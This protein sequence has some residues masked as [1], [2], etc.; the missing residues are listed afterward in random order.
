MP[1]LERKI[2]I[3]SSPD[4]IYKIV[5]DGIN[6]PKWNPS[7][8]AVIEKEDK[9]IQLETNIGGITI[10]DTKNEENKSTT[11][12]MESSD[13]NSIGYILNPKKTD[14]TEVTMWTEFDNKKQLK[15][16]KKTADRVLEGLK[17]YAEYIEGGGDPD[18]YKKWEYL[19]TP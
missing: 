14:Y 9:K 15:L 18:Q 19:T 6:T 4:K 13:M 5:T 2:K 10:I 16:F 8:N 11:W 3:E 12:Y 17:T 1:S 7:V